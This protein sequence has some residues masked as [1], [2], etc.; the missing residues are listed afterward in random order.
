MLAVSDHGPFLP[1]ARRGT[2]RV[3][4]LVSAAESDVIVSTTRIPALLSPCPQLRCETAFPGPPAH[5]GTLRTSGPL[6]DASGETNDALGRAVF[7]NQTCPIGALTSMCAGTAPASPIRPTTNRAR[8]APR[9]SSRFGAGGREDPAVLRRQIASGPAAEPLGTS[10]GNATHGESRFPAPCR[11]AAVCIHALVPPLDRHLERVDVEGGGDDDDPG[12][13]VA[14]GFPVGRADAQGSSAYESAGGFRDAT[15]FTH[16]EA[17]GARERLSGTATLDGGLSWG[18][19][20]GVQRDGAIRATC[21]RRGLPKPTSDGCD[22]HEGRGNAEQREGN[23]WSGT[24]AFVGAG[25]HGR[26]RE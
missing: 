14:L 26:G 3:T 5:D 12:V 21:G 7:R 18:A 6:R 15:F 1:R 22:G 23:R 19:A 2:H 11:L 10:E 4:S 13:D 25:D 16:R 17:R 9:V 8:V 24:L 20:P